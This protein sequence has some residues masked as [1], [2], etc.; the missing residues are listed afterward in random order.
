MSI[1][2]IDKYLIQ[3]FEN[4]NLTFTQILFVLNI[5]IN[6]INITILENKDIKY[7]FLFETIC[8]S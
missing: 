5:K 4:N 8:I 1:K 2:D 6:F 3:L 7:H